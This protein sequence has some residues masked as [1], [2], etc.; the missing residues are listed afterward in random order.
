MAKTVKIECDGCG[1]DLTYTGNSADYRLVVSAEEKPTYPGLNI[2]TD[3][4]IYPPIDR[5]YYFC[6]LACLDKWRDRQHH[7]NGLW[8]EW[9]TTWKREHG[10]WEGDRCRSWTEPPHDLREAKRA[11]FEAAALAAVP[12]GR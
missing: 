2:V 7:E 9:M 11:E 1:H 6:R 12:I 4:M 8:R 10:A 5:V 3:M